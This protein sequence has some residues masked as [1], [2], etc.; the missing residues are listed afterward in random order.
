MW[1]AANKW[2]NLFFQCRKCVAR[3]RQNAR[4]NCP[5]LSATMPVHS[6]C[7]DQNGWNCSLFPYAGTTNCFWQFDSGQLPESDPAILS[8][9]NFGSVISLGSNMVLGVLGSNMVCGVRLVAFLLGFCDFLRIAT[10]WNV[11]QHLS[12]RSRLII[13]SPTSSPKELY[14][15]LG[16]NKPIFSSC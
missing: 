10:G 8:R 1:F 15:L 12:H 5:D 3:L 6:A 7:T 11:M 16:L 4:E 9:C 14:L 2:R 13:V